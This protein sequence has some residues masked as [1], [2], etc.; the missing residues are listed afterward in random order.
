MR[1]TAQ[2]MV[3]MASI[4]ISCMFFS[5]VQ[6]ER[7]GLTSLLTC[8]RV[9]PSFLADGAGPSKAMCLSRQPPGGSHP[10]THST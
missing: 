4:G 3:S 1:V 2:A 9:D 10:L 5:C 6:L 8:G 7:A